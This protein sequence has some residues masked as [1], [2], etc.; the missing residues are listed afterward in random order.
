MAMGKIKKL[1]IAATILLSVVSFTGCD[2]SLQSSEVVSRKVSADTSQEEVSSEDNAKKTFTA[3][4]TLFQDSYNTYPTGEPNHY[5]T[6]DEILS[7]GPIVSDW[8]LLNGKNVVMKNETDFTLD[9]VTFEILG[10]N[11]SVIDI[12]DKHGKVVLSLQ[13][14]GEIEGSYIFGANIDMDWVSIDPDKKDKGKDSDMKDKGKHSDEND[15]GKIT[16]VFVWMEVNYGTGEIKE[17]IPNG[18]FTLT[19]TYR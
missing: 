17:V 18:T 11:R 9:P 1:L 8:K 5:E 19:G 14:E 3:T 7:G 15:G 13:A 10:I 6:T 16:G 2:A 4:V 12:V